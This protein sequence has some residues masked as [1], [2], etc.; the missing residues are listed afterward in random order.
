MGLLLQ[1]GLR[2]TG[3]KDRQLP[4]YARIT[5]NGKRI[6]LSVK[7]MMN[8]L[9]WNEKRG[10]AKGINVEYTRLNNYLDQLKNSYV[11]C[12]SEMALQK[13]E[14]TTDTFKNEFFSDT[15]NEYTLLKLVN[16]HNREVQTATRKSA[17]K[18]VNR[19]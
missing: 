10:A 6:E 19:N 2:N 16:Y 11:A 7:Q 3:Q 13:K 15:D 1:C 12:Y 9:H 8:P 18:N 5:I 4:I 17:R 14:I